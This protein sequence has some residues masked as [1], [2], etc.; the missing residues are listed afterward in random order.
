[1]KYSPDCSPLVSCSYGSANT[2]QKRNQFQVKRT[3]ELLR[4]DHAITLL[5]VAEPVCWCPIVKRI[6]TI[7]GRRDYVIDG[8]KQWM[9]GMHNLVRDRQAAQVAPRRVSANGT[10]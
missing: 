9:S 1:M 8:S 4:I 6:G 10:A 3:S 7:P 2:A 5:L